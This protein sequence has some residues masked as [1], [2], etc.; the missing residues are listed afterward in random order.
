MIESM[1]IR[2][3]A[4][5]SDDGTELT[6]LKKINFVYGANGSGKTTIS[7]FSVNLD[8]E[9]FK[10][11]SMQWSQNQKLQCLAYN[12]QFRD[13][14]FGKGPIAGVFT[15][16]QATTEELK[17]IEEKQVELSNLKAEG[18]KLKSS[19]DEIVAKKLEYENDLKER[20]W[21]NIYKQHEVDLKEA[22]KNAMHKESFKKRLL[23]EFAN[24]TSQAQTLPDLR[25]KS[26]TIF[27]DAPKELEPL[28]TWGFSRIG[29]I[30]ADG[31]WMEKIVGKAD[32]DISK[33]IASLNIND[34]VSQGVHYITADSTCPFC[35]QP[36][37][38]EEFRTQLENYFD[39]TFT[40]SV[41]KIGSLA[42]EYSNQID[43][44]FHT[45][46]QIETTQK[47]ASD[48]KLNLELF[49]AWLRSLTSQASQNRA[50][51]ADK[52]KEPSRPIKLAR[53]VDGFS[54]ISELV[55]R[56]NDEIEKHNG[57]VLNFSTE[58]NNLINAVWRYLVE[59]NKVELQEAIRKLTGLQKGIDALKEK[60]DKKR[61]DYKALDNEIKD[62]T[63]NVTS[64]QPTVDEIN[65]TLI[66]YGF[67]N[68]EIVPAEGE[69]NHYQIKRENGDLAESTLSEGEVTF[70]T[71]L[72]YLQLAKGAVKKDAITDERV[73]IIDDPISSLDSNVLFVVGSLVKRVIKDVKNNVGSIKQLI[74]LTHN[75]Y[76]HKE[77]SFIDARTKECAET[78]FWILRKSKNIT[79]A[80]AYLTRN[81]IKTSYEL[82]WAEIKVENISII[83]VQNSMRRIIENYF[84]LL[85][86]YKDIDLV[87]KFTSNE[88]RDIFRSLISW[89]NDGSHSISDDLFVESQTD[90]V[91]KYL[92][93]FKS[94]FYLT[95]HG[96][97]YEMMMGLENQVPS[98]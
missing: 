40:E 79:S 60:T 17:Q 50:L 3:T 52:K 88:E 65:R 42:D 34:W 19:Y 92:E 71:F 78:H 44:V 49:S 48:S 35:Q 11:C 84:K 18:L 61:T 59:S 13:N 15:L 27:G 51:I 1:S 33:L 91:E 10:D 95:N 80:Q 28:P 70:I 23:D 82:L 57:I 83:T 72:Y 64:V 29:E 31:A 77:A 39:S 37:I 69:S 4:S 14:N 46:Q 47:Q 22:F 90:V 81:P 94:V 54:Q 87:N 43:D 89:V 6:G 20:L 41:N 66:F 75:V 25:E 12:K 62:L 30:E 96:G 24:N 76:F 45:L 5:Y 98:E 36:T 8:D 68:F 55:K 93:V 67:E 21:R 74:L 16:G 85:G 56:A 2:N 63:S 26:K 86:G 53:T 9:E 73:L 38:T 97:H 32:V 7:N 58:K